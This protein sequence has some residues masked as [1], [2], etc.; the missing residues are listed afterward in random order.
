MSSNKLFRAASCLHQAS[1][2]GGSHS[3]SRFRL[4]YDTLRESSSSSGPNTSS[5]LL[6]VRQELCST[7]RQYQQFKA[8]TRSLTANALSVPSRNES[9]EPLEKIEGPKSTTLFVNAHSSMLPRFDLEKSKKKKEEEK[10]EKQISPTNRYRQSLLEP[11]NEPYTGKPLILD[12]NADPAK[13]GPYAEVYSKKEQI[14]R[15]FSTQ[16]RREKR[17]T[18]V[19]PNVYVKPD[20]KLSIYDYI[21]ADMQIMWK[22]RLMETFLQQKTFQLREARNRLGQTKNGILP[23]L[24]QLR[25]QDYVDIMFDEACRLTE[26][27]D[28]HGLP[29][30]VLCN[31]LGRKVI[32]RIR[33]ELA[34][35][36]GIIDKIADTYEHYAD[37]FMDWPSFSRLN[38]REFW[39]RCAIELHPEDPSLDINPL[40]RYSDRQLQELGQFL[41]EV[42]IES[43]KV[44][45]SLT[46]AV[47]A[48]RSKKTI[49]GE[50][51][52]V[53]A[54]FK[55]L[56]TY[57]VR[58][59]GE[60][61]P[62]GS[63]MWLKKKMVRSD[64]RFDTSEMPMI[65]PP[66]PWHRHDQGQQLVRPID[67]IRLEPDNVK[68]LRQVNNRV[69]AKNEDMHAV[70]DALNVLGSTP[71]MINQPVF[72]VMLEV[73]RG[74]G[75]MKLD[76][77]PAQSKLP[78]LPP[79]TKGLSR[80]EKAAV[81]KQRQEMK[82]T[83]A[84]LYSLW[85]T[86]NYRFSLANYFKD[87]VIW[88]PH[89]LDFRG[90]TYPVPP[91]LNHMGD[92]MC[93]GMMR[94]AKGRPL[95]K[96]G[97]KWLKIHLINLTGLQK[98]ASVEDRAKYADEIM[99]DV[100]DSARNPLDGRRWWTKSEEPW[101]TLAVCMEIEKAMQLER[102]EEYVCYVP[103]HQDGS[104][105]GLQHYAALGRDQKGAEQ[106]CHGFGLGGLGMGRS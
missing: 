76:I 80:E 78:P 59:Y 63:L 101:Q 72:D 61:R 24:C 100:L 42:M 52:M 10:S 6:R 93:R 37:Y 58:C 88:F 38:H 82:K 32:S 95:G 40:V 99:D 8:R 35:K 7:L 65:C 47:K 49:I 67:M 43:V 56:S 53:N 18:L 2:S 68:S 90:R 92:D 64:I 30:K 4:P 54:F 33:V 44:P 48:Y 94:F 1:T 17:G 9:F 21:F 3:I 86:V 105:N 20:T 96:D 13:G 15:D 60:I 87:K 11:L 102:P 45:S 104:C 84:E 69:S 97:L 5:D 22:D 14:L 91:H 83:H 51:K 85:C 62:H 31:N 39:R 103:I 66:I 89:N 25:N 55:C 36:H 106:V 16:L 19:V 73:F 79:V 98:R 28:C 74:D 75:D 12:P 26:F 29:L 46:E 77:P 27:S 81:M 41:Y 57:N 71:W 50:T 23:F 34:E 70:M